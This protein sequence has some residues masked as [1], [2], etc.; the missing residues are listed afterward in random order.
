[1]TKKRLITENWYNF[2]KSPFSREQE[3]EMYNSG[4]PTG[5]D[6]N[7]SQEEI[8]ILEAKIENLQAT[9]QAHQERID[10]LRDQIDLDVHSAS[11]TGTREK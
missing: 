9:I 6:T 8:Y 10:Y 1:M 7:T 11:Q 4:D 2:I 5:A 3:Q